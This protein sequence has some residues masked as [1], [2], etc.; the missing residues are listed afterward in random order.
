[1]FLKNLAILLNMT[2]IKTGD[3]EEEEISEERVPVET[4]QGE[5]IKGVQIREAPIKAKVET[6]QIMA[7]I[8]KAGEINL[9]NVFLSQ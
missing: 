8:P 3:V 6:G 2:R 9:L 4:G 7:S 5:A 1:V